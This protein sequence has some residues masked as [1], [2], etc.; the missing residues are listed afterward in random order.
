MADGEDHLGVGILDERIHHDHD[1]DGD[2]NPKVPDDPSQLR[3]AAEP[4]VSARLFPISHVVP[5][6]PIVTQGPCSSQFPTP[7]HALSLP[8][9]WLLSLGILRR[10]G[11]P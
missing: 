6:C 11:L 4:A 9:P 7:F 1:Q 3:A 10:G 2:G 5:F 8:P